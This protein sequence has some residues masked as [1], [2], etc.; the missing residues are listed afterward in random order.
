MGF[1][2]VIQL[3][4]T[5]KNDDDEEEQSP[6]KTETILLVIEFFFDP[7]DEHPLLYPRTRPRAPASALNLPKA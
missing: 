2:R 5:H 4:R 1:G 3:K 7:T 6:G